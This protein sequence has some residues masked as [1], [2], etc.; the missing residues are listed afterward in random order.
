MLCYEAYRKQTGF[1]VLRKGWVF[2]VLFTGV[3][4]GMHFGIYELLIVAFFPFI[5]LS[6][7]YNAGW[8]K[9]LLDTSPL[10]RLGEWSFSVYLV[11]IPLIY[12]GYCLMLLDNPK[13]L[14]TIQEFGYF[15]TS[16]GQAWLYCLGMVGATLLTSALLY[17]YVEVP[18]RRFINARF[19][20][21]KPKS[22][23]AT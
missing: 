10:Q 22:A 17:H 3:L 5:I 14:S 2:V 9:R 20:T 21:T 13:R 11:H 16:Y 12:A 18:S 7:A 4:A 15:N 8:L 1:P 23:M 6:A 19:K